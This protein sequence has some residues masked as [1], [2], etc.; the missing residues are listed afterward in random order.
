MYEAELLQVL[1]EIS[2]NL[3]HIAEALE[4]LEKKGG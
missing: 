4:K 2:Q 3:K 1:R